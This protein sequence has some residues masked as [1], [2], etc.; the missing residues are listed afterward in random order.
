MDVRRTIIFLGLAI[1]SYFLFLA[2]NQ[3]YG[4]S[5]QLQTADTEEKT[6]QPVDSPVLDTPDTS[7][8]VDDRPM[9]D[10]VDW[11]AEKT[12]VFSNTSAVYV[13]TDVLDIRDRKSVV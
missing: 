6:V 9:T 5:A 3:D 4:Q 13:K 1:S 11:A 12:Q 10:D 7:A 2:W 8:P